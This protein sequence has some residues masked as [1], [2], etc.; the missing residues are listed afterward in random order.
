M[1]FITQVDR[2]NSEFIII[3]MNEKLLHQVLKGPRFAHWNNAEIGS[4][5]IYERSNLEKFNYKVGNT[6]VYFHN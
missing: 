2:S 5:I 3:N 4:H 6:L 1:T